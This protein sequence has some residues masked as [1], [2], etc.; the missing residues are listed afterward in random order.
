[1]WNILLQSCKVGR[2]HKVSQ[3]SFQFYLAL[4]PNYVL[5]W[6]AKSPFLESHRWRKESLEAVL[7]WLHTGW[8]TACPYIIVQICS[9]KCFT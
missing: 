6:R 4:T 2:Q 8:F 7:L 9:T 3:A 1:M 5:I